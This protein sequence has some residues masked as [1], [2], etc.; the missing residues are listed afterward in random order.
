MADTPESNPR[1]SLCGAGMAILAFDE[2]SITWWCDGI[3]G[4]N[5]WDMP[6]FAPDRFRNDQHAIRST[7]Q[8]P[9]RS[10]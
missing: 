5:K 4:W 9:R 8:S 3:V 2:I 7:L 1:C 10:R 6:R